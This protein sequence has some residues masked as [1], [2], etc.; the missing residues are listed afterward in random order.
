MFMGLREGQW[1]LLVSSCLRSTN[2]V[3]LRACE[4]A[5]SQTI[6][7]HP[8]TYFDGKRKLNVSNK[9]LSESCWAKAVQGIEQQMNQNKAQKSQQ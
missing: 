3:N 9:F 2:R 5:D 7:I 4:H 6:W 1:T 8:R